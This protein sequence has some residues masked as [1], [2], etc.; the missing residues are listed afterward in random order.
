MKGYYKDEE[1]IRK[2][3]NFDGWLF[4]GD[5][6]VMDEDG[7]CCIIGRLK[8]MFIRG[9]ENIYLWEI[10]EFLYWYFDILDV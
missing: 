5:F 1:V 9:G 8:D 3:I 2:V 10:E 7:Y 4:I 6:V